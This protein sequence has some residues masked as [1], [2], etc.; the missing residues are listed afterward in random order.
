MPQNC[1][2]G[3]RGQDGREGQDRLETRDG[4]E[5]NPY[6]PTANRFASTGGKPAST[7]LACAV[8]IG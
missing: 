2:G 3:K 5:D 4:Q 1:A 8:S 7:T 6:R